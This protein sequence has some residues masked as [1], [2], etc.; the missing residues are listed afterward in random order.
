[1]KVAVIG[2]GAAGFFSALSAKK[3]HPYAEV[4]LFEKSK[5]LL[6]KV[7]ISGG[8]RCNVTNGS[9]SIKELSESYPRGKNLMKKV[10]KTFNTGDTRNWFE[11]RGVPLKVEKDGRVFPKSDNSESIID[12][13]LHES[14]KYDIAIKIEISIIQIEAL[15]D[16]QFILKSKSEEYA[17]DKVI[18]ATGGSPKLSGF[19]WIKD[20]GHEIVPPV[21]SLFTFNMPTER[22]KDLM[23]IVAPNASVSIKGTNLKTNGPVLITHW[24]MSGPAVLKLSAYGARILNELNYEF[25]II[26]NWINISNQEEV[27]TSLLE[28]IKEHPKKHLASFRPFELPDRLWHFLLDKLDLDSSKLWVEIGNK[29]INKIISILCNDAY[30]VSGKTTFKEEFVT[31]GGVSLNDIYSRS[32]ESKICKGLYFAGE[33]MDIDG[34]TGGYNFQAAWGTGYIAG[35]LL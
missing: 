23:G 15:G 25:K 35:K 34:I 16:N 6:S 10:L 3:H 5:K 8:G 4:T 19:D 12:C 24:G 11:S 7:R 17:L 18:I 26:V 28:I 1:M 2:G 31:A 21:P 14:Q 22:V 20:L 27:K 32:M 29:G 30:S 33:V 9:P 13:L